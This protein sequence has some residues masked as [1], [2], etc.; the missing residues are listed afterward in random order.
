M[1]GTQ[2]YFN[3]WLKAQQDAFGSV[4]EMTRKFQQNLSGFGS[5]GGAMPG[6]GGAMPGFGGAM[7]G[8][9]GALPGFGSAM[10]GFGGF[11]DVYAA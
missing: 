7:P 9:G 10:P 2:E 1:S 4:G 11:Q 6:F 3:A 8:F 5:T